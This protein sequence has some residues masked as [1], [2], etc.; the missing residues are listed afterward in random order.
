[1]TVAAVWQHRF[2]RLALGIL[3]AQ[4]LFWGTLF[5][6]GETEKEHL[7]MKSWEVGE[8]YVHPLPGLD[9]DFGA[10][11]EAHR[12]TFPV[13]PGDCYRGYHSPAYQISFDVKGDEY[14]NWA[15]YLPWVS[16]NFETYVNGRLIA[17][18]RGQFSLTPSREERRPFLIG[19]PRDLMEPG[20][21]RVDLVVTRSGCVP[22]VQTV[23]FG[24]LE[25]FKAYES[26]MV[27][28]GHYVPIITAVAGGLVALVALCLLP[29]SGYS[30]LFASLAAFM[31]AL[32]LRAFAYVWAG[33]GIEFTTFFMV[34]YLIHYL[35]LATAAYFIQA[36][37]GQPRHHT[38]WFAAIFAVFAAVFAAV[39]WPGGE[40]YAL[41]TQV[42]NPVSL[43]LVSGYT[44][45]SLWRMAPSRPGEA[46]RAIVLMSLFLSSELYDALIPIFGVRRFI[47]AAYYLPI[48]L[49]A[50]VAGHLA[51]RGY[52]LYRDLAVQVAEKEVEIRASY[53]RLQE[54]ENLNAIHTERQRLIRDMH[55]GI[56]GQLVS[57]MLQLKG[58]AVPQE[59]VHQQVQAAV[60]DLRLIIDSMDSVGDSLD[61]ALAI[62][63]DRMQPRLKAAGIRFVFE[64][65]LDGEVQG[66]RPQEILHIYR[67]LQEG[68][69]N[70]LKYAGAKTVRLEIEAGD[71]AETIRLRL[72]DDGVGFDVEARPETEGGRGLN[73]MHKRARTLGGELTVTAAPGLGTVLTLTVK[74]P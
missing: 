53:A 17:T 52:R 6:I 8:I 15:L 10:R 58:K 21:N 24:P 61:I 23:Y 46:G 48:V 2:V 64:N 60:D 14:V 40:V 35:C 47:D 27:L 36:W 25:P 70:I 37:T 39:W 62:F 65:R 33:N 43:L 71:D 56:G 32:A 59:R 19:I 54:Q 63:R 41:V 13:E 73:H 22:Y 51:V 55:D 30:P 1:M 45:W 7:N 5:L 31:A 9:P 20:T 68:M 12:Q 50:A 44:I 49:I 28:L 16:D 4:I 74:R 67:I 11:D 26:H 57:L 34:V 66:F 38:R 42:L 18:P 29:I 69:T 72:S 3:G